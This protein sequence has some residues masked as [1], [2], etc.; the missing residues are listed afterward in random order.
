MEK[1]IMRL[2]KAFAVLAA[3]AVIFTGC[4]GGSDSATSPVTN[5]SLA[6]TYTLKTVN[7]GPLPAVIQPGTAEVSKIEVLSDVVTVKVDGTW[8]GVEQF[9]LTTGAT[10]EMQTVNSSGTYTVSGT[11]VTFKDNLDGSLAVAAVS[12]DS[13]TLN[14]GSYVYSR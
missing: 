11:T 2:P 5:A 13:F 14:D 6:G 1:N 7:G 9:R 12:G 4:G 8:N 3:G 10:I